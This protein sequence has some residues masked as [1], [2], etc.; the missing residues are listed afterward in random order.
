[1]LQF[2]AVEHGAAAMRHEEA[3]LNEKP[4]A[5]AVGYKLRFVVRQRSS[6]Y[7]IKADQVDWI[8]SAGNYLRLHTRKADYLV[9]GTMAQLEQELH[10]DHFAR[11]HRST[12]VNLDRIAE[13]RPAP[14]GDYEVILTT[15]KRL[16]LSRHYKSRII[17]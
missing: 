12:I 11:I 14:F 6:L 8:E 13:I 1:M 3:S 15:G 16:R 4:V 2:G 10:P 5:R 17:D 7:L 9:R